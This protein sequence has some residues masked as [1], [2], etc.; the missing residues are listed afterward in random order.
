MRHKL[1]A[2]LCQQQIPTTLKTCVVACQTHSQTDNRTQT[3]TEITYKHS[4]FI[5]DK[6][7]VGRMDLAGAGGLAQKGLK[8]NRAYTQ[9]N[10]FTRR[11]AN[12]NCLYASVRV[13]VC[14]CICA[15]A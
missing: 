5:R 12:A 10:L 1:A 14:V 11:K 2:A 6:V 7:P 4:N 9:R 8:D 15:F 3:S 13:C